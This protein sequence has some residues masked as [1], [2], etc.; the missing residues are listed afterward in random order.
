MTR[1]RTT[2]RPTAH[3][4][5]EEIELGPDVICI[6]GRVEHGDKRG[7]ELGFPTANVRPPDESL[8]DGVYAA[9]CTTPDGRAWPAA[10]S[11]GRRPTFY[12]ESTA[13]QLV[14]AH[15]IGFRGDLYG[16]QVEV[17][18]IR[19]LRGQVPFNGVDGLVRQMRRDVAQT[20][21]LLVGST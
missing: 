10:V 12:D 21:E 7:R 9:W 18:L 4:D 5:A 6:T 14:E 1:S 2:P 13:V 16:Q 3:A 19:R 8:R 11:V 15:L 20:L 17:R